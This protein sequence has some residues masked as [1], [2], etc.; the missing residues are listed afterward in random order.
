MA[1]ELEHVG[2]RGGY[3]SQKQESQSAAD[4]VED[5]EE[6]SCKFHPLC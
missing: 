6:E 1:L 2:S 5:R 3:Y 4:A